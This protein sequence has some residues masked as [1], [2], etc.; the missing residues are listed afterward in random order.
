MWEQYT[1]ERVTRSPLLLPVH[2]FDDEHIIS[3]FYFIYFPFGAVQTGGG[4]MKHTQLI[5]ISSWMRFNVVFFEL[6][7]I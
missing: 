5:I 4:F 2:L 1:P 3:K 7:R 6:V